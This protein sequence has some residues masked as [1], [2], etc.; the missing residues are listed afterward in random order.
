MIA[1][2]R[3]Y[4]KHQIQKCN[5]SYVEIKDVFND[6]DLALT[7]LKRGYKLNFGTL[8]TNT[9]GNYH[10]D[11]VDCSLEI[12]KISSEKSELAD[13][14]EVYDLAINIK[15]TILDP[16]F[17][18]TSNDFTD[19]IFNSISP[20]PLPS[21]DKVFRILLTFQIRKDLAYHGV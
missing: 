1:A 18:K 11:I 3:A 14:D 2:S 21:N 7:E 5:S 9:D 20:E 17:V 6:D 4:I 10:T 19:I 15:N 16:E 12:Y 13:H 8:A